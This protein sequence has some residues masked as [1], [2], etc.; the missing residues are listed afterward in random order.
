MQNDNNNNGNQQGK[1]HQAPP[2]QG[3]TLSADEG[4]IDIQRYFFM[5]LARWWIILLFLLIGAGAGV[6][7]YMNAE[8]VYRASCTY[9]L[10]QPG[11]G[12]VGSEEGGTLPRLEQKLER[13]LY[14]LQSGRIKGRTWRNLKSEWAGQLEEAGSIPSV[15]VRQSN[16]IPTIIHINADSLNGE[17]A[18]AYLKEMLNVYQDYQRKHLMR[19]KERSLEKL[20]EE[21]RKIRKDLRQAQKKL[22]AFESE[23]NI[24]FTKTKA[25]YDEKFLAKL[26]QRKNSIRMERTMLKSQFPFLQ[27]AS[28]VTIRDVLA[29]NRETH[30]LTAGRAGMPAQT[31]S[32]QSNNNNQGRAMTTS[33]RGNVTTSWPKK[34]GWKST[35]AKL[36]QLQGEYEDKL[37]IY[38]KSHPKMVKL[39]KRI[40]ETERKLEI[41]AKIAFQRLKNRYE[42]LKIQGKSLA[43]AAQNWRRELNLS[44]ETQAEYEQLR[45]KVS[46]YKELY[47][48]VYTHILDSSLMDADSLYSKVLNKPHLRGSPIAPD[49]KK[50]LALPLFIA[51]VASGGVIFLLEQCQSGVLDVPA[52]EQ[53]LGIPYLCGVPDWAQTDKQFK[54]KPNRI[55]VT[56]DKS[57]VT[58]EVYRTMRTS[59]EYAINGQTP[60]TLMVSSDLKGSGK[61]LTTLNLAV[62]MSWTGKKVLLVDADLRRGALHRDLGLE[63]GKGLCQLLRGEVSDWKDIVYKTQYETLDLVQSGRFSHDVPEFLDAQRLRELFNSFHEHYDYVI[64]DSAPISMVADPSVIASACDG[65]LIL[66]DHENTNFN[67]VRHAAHRLAN[68]N[69]IGFCLNSITV[70]KTRYGYYRYGYY[71][72]G[73]Y[74]YPYAYRKYEGYEATE[75]KSKKANA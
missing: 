6:Y 35:K 20:R 13:Q 27:D 29:L 64:L 55:L 5:I 60:Y 68:A 7:K 19:R 17:Y 22:R 28:A 31:T 43:Q 14:A 18:L 72:Y 38:K 9:E 65:T 73:H 12:T 48:K 26:V 3:E 15:H 50:A 61:S 75:N 42:A 47:D 71:Q 45:S 23:H 49:K 37:D 16:K 62:T 58:T 1:F 46:H 67:Y 69:I 34:A 32:D 36:Q 39:R 10:S 41:S 74:Y 53:R 59:V 66:I 25:E 70:P 4:G 11:I 51:L 2:Q 24:R 33:P 63:R 54:R 40:H 44:T 8:P 30:D 56:R 21:Q 57:D 52:I